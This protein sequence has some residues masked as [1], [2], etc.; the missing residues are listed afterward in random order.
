MDDLRR[1]L[2]P[3]LAPFP[4]EQRALLPAL[5]AVQHELGWLPLWAL[6]AVGEHLRVPRSEVHGV[7]SHYPELRLERPAAHLARVCT[8]LSC[9]AA[10]ADAILEALARALEVMPGEIR[11]DGAVRLETHP[12]SF[13]CGVAPV[14][15]L[16]GEARAGL[17][18]A[19]A[20][21]AARACLSEAA[22]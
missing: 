18:P 4:R 7:A 2:T 13:I 11:A 1:D 15:E 16:D 19:E 9:R 20:V 10:G 8:G 6:A 21:T 12:C 5:E 17:S 3:L 22:R 14:I